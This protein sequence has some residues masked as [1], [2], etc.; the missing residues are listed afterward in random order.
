MR[1]Q[2]DTAERVFGEALDRRPE[3][4][5]AFLD[6]RCDGQ[7]ALRGKVDALLKE[8][9]RLQGFL[10]ESPLRPQDNGAPEHGISAGTRLGHYSV[11]ELLGSGG[12]GQV[13]RAVDAD[14]RR[15]VALKVL[16][17]D[18]D[19]NA[20]RVARF[21]R[22]ARA[23]A[24][25][26]HPNICTIYEIG[27]QDGRIFIA[28]EF[29]E[30]MT[31]QQRIAHPPLDLDT[32]LTLAIEIADALDAAHTAGIVHR[33][34]KPAN[35]FVTSRGH[36]KV[37]DFGLAKVIRAST[38]GDSSTQLTSPGSPM[39][40]VAYMSPEQVRGKEV[41]VRTDLFSFGVVLYE[42]VTGVRPFR[43]ES[44]ALTYEAILNGTPVSPTRLNLD[45]P[46]GL[47]DIVN[48]ALEKDCD[49][50]YQ[51]AADIRA[52]LKRM[53]R[54]TESGRVSAAG[55]RRDAATPTA[56]SARRI[57]IWVW[58]VVGVILLAVAWLMRPALPPPQ[59]TGVL[60][61]TNDDIPKSW[62]DSWALQNPLYTDGSRIYFEDIS[63]IAPKLREVS[64]EGG[65][66]ETLGGERNFSLEGI[67]PDGSS[68]LVLANPG[69]YSQIDSEP[70]FS[71]SLPGLR[72]RRIGDLTGGNDA[73]AWSPDGRTLYSDIGS[74]TASSSEIVATDADGGNRR[75]LFSVP[76][77]P[78]WLRVS[79]DGRVMRLSVEDTTGRGGSSLWEANIDGSHLH[80]MLN[81]W[82]NDVD[83][84]C[85]SWTPDGKY[86]I[87]QS[88]QNGKSSLWAVRETADALRKVSHEPVELT[89]GEMSA[90]SPLP[91]EDG[92]RVFFIGSVRRGEVMRYDQKT[93]SLEPFLTG[94]SA[95]GLDFSKDGQRMVWTSFPDG[96]LWQSKVDGSDKIQLTFPPMGAGTGRWSPDGTQIAFSG[97][98]PGKRSQLYMIPSRGGQPEQLTPSVP[99]SGDGT[100]SPDGE[101]IAY[102]GT[103]SEGTHS[104]QI[105]GFK[106]RHVTAVP[107]SEGLI[108]PRWSPDGKYLLAMPLD[109]SRLMLFDFAHQ[110][111]QD[112]T[113]ENLQF[114]A[115]PAWLPD[116]KC[117]VFNSLGSSSFPEYR[118]CLADRKLEHIA[119]MGQNGRLVY[120]LD[121]W[122]T[123]VAPDGSI[124]GTRD[125]STQEIYALDVKW[126]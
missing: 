35:I 11:V 124:L 19:G 90:E 76:G 126:P 121:G 49:L 81:G 70:L 87:F 102:L 72:E 108:S 114:A 32:A 50:R 5:A 65:E 60:Q 3:E 34:I 79:P 69:T 10:S 88:T 78:I 48:K 2:E 33:D 110:S 26:N 25:L 28:M 7:P 105:V 41:D 46:A 89:Q 8:H 96:I 93:H 63:A 118:I 101:S 13:Y 42:M 61:L 12:M 39:G 53:K 99:S 56:I 107:K 73:H 106:T 22:E 92:K 122:W 98:Y 59:V 80:H 86:F 30:G 45:L 21:R 77:R 113:P 62:G 64:I 18:M 36:A 20:E 44:T 117:V 71:L 83:L 97:H 100:W 66:S 9:D 58:P 67:S 125:A 85:G 17:R 103:N 54:D 51:H 123:G 84:C 112:L 120:G 6:R 82:N 16:P 95:V 57:P 27:E 14:L 55:G 29:M 31:L 94:F 74:F 104:L 4:R 91:S 109:F 111:W 15:D 47:E 75:A 23:L 40:T 37:L 119:D 38:G 115:Y 116:S 24:V 52:D 1:N 43:G 68:L